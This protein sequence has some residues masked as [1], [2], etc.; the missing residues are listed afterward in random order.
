M[1]RPKGSKNKI[2]QV[3]V[4][5]FSYSTEQRI[6]LIAELIVQ[7]IIDDRR[8]GRHLLAIAR[9]TNATND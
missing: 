3:P 6:D 9:G 1:S 7:R 5:E 2:Q 8:N 4:E